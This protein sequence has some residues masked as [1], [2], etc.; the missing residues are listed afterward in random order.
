[1]DEYQE[2]LAKKKRISCTLNADNTIS[3]DQF[4][5]IRPSMNNLHEFVA[6]ED[7]CFFEVSLPNYTADVLR[8]ITYFS[9]VLTSAE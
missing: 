9:E 7:T 1:M 6:L 5:I 3:D 8:R 4:M 2:L